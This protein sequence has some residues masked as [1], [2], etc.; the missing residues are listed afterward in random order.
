MNVEQLVSLRRYVGVKIAGLMAGAIA[1]MVGISTVAIAPI[2]PVAAQQAP[3]QRAPS[4]DD[5]LEQG[6]DL[7]GRRDW[8][9]ALVVY[10]Q[11]AQ[12]ESD[13]ARIFAIIGYVQVQQGNFPAAAA[14]YQQA[15]ALDNK[16]A[17]FFYALGNSLANYDRK[18]VA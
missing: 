5:L 6:E 18:Y 10:Q 17:E 12:L 1:S 13:N 4:I 8:E 2:L 11:A 16:N 9:G 3:V 15:T 14:A 7:V